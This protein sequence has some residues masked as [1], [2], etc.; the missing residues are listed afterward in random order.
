MADDMNDDYG[1]LLKGLESYKKECLAS[2]TMVNEQN[3][4]IHPTKF[5]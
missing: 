5:A 2:T 4:R 3:V 1:L